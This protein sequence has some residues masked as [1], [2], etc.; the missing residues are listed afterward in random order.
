[1]LMV[2]LSAGKLPEAD[3]GHLHQTALDAPVERRVPLDAPYHHHGIGGVR[4]GVHE[5][6]DPVVRCSE[7][8][9]VGA[10][11]DRAVHRPL[12][13]P[14]MGEDVDL[15]LGRRGAMAAHRGHDEGRHPVSTPVLDHAPHDSSDVCD[16]AAAD[17][18]RDASARAE[19]RGEATALQLPPRLRTHVVEAAIREI[20][21][22][23]QEAGRKHHSSTDV[24]VSFI[25]SQ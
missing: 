11:D 10:A 9:D 6:F 14:E 18:N 22:N 25:S 17:A 3:G 12:G 7:R 2:F 16:A 8:D 19:P 13:D 1:M 20:L 15:A 4:R 21:T 23:D 5:H 24:T